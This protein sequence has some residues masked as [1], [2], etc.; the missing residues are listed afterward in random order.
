MLVS[1]AK[2]G[3][4][5]QVGVRNGFLVAA[6]PDHRIEGHLF[7]VDASYTL[8][9]WENCRFIAWEEIPQTL[10]QYYGGVT[11]SIA[12]RK[13]Y[14]IPAR[15]RFGHSIDEKVEVILLPPAKTSTG[16]FMTAIGLGAALSAISQSAN[17][18]SEEE[19][20]T[21]APETR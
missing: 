20:K 1:Q 5:V 6:D 10:H 16:F 7:K 2:S 4:K 17:H 9:N 18:S 12:E 19:H 11:I 15:F 21:R 14:R 8:C 3:S 13:K